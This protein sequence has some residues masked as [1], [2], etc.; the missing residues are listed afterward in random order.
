MTQNPTIAVD[1]KILQAAREAARAASRYEKLV[2]RKLGITGEIGEVLI[3]QALNLLLM[4]DPLAAGHDAVDARGRTYQIKTRRSATKGLPRDVGKMG[5]FSAHPFHFAVLGILDTNY[6]LVEVWQAP[7]RK[8]LP[9]IEA[10]K[11]R[12]PRLKAF[13][14]VAQAMPIRANQATVQLKAQNPRG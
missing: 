12:S 2:G 5:R 9:L 14:A 8:V 4:Q 6:N 7:Y 11:Y 3:C 13:K 10:D 1:T